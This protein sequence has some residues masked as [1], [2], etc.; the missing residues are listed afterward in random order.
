MR[1]D[2]RDADDVNQTRLDRVLFD[3]DQ[4]QFDRF[5]QMLDEPVAENSGIARL[6]TI[7][8]HWL[9]NPER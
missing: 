7:T 5:L 8:S 3:V 1:I 2:N 6:M 4:S 9:S